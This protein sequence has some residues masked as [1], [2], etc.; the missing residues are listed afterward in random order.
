MKSRRVLLVDDDVSVTRT[1]AMYL[2]DFG[3]CEVRTENEGSRALAAARQFKPDL[4]I[5]DIVMPEADG[6]TVAAEIGADPALR[7]TPIVFLTALVSPRETGGGAQQIGGH[8]FLAKPVEPD[9][10]LHYVEKYARA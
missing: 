7:G 3:D 1:L 6:G 5:L 8:P 4:V 9:V 2:Q 10:V